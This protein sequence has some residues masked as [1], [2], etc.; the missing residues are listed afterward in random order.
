MG[1]LLTPDSIR[2]RLK[3]YNIA[4]AALFDGSTGYLSYAPS[5]T[6]N[7]R[8]WTT[9]FWVMRHGTG[10]DYYLNSNQYTGSSGIAALYHENDKV[11]QYFHSNTTFPYGYVAINKHIDMSSFYMI[12]WVVDSN[13]N[14]SLTYIDGVLIDDSTITPASGFDFGINKAGALMTFGKAAWGTSAYGNY[15]IANLHHIDGQALVPTD[16]AELD[17]RT[18]NWK[19]KKYTGTYG[20]NGFYLDFSDAGALGTDVSG[21]GNNWIVNGTV[22]QVRSTPTNTYA[23]WN[24]LVYNPSNTYSNGNLTVSEGTATTWRSTESTLL[25]PAKSNMLVYAECY[26]P[27]TS[28]TQQG[29]FGVNDH[30]HDHYIYGNWVGFWAYDVANGRMIEDGVDTTGYTSSY[31]A[32]NYG[33]ALD[34]ANKKAWFRLN[35]GSWEGGGDPVAGTLPSVTWTHENDLTLCVQM[36]QSNWTL[37]ANEADWTYTPP[38]GF[39]SLCTDYLPAVND[40]I[41]HHFKTVLYVGTPTPQNVNT[42]LAQVDFAWIK[43]RSGPGVDGVW[44]TGYPTIWDNCRPGAHLYTSDIY[45]EYESYAA[46]LSG[47]DI[48]INTYG[49]TW[50]NYDSDQYVAWCASLPKTKTSGWTGSPTIIPLKEIYNDSAMFKMSIVKYIGNGVAG[51]TI[52]HSL[53]VKPGFVIVKGVS[54]A[55]DWLCY[56]SALGATQRIYLNRTYA[57]S[58]ATTAW[59]DTEPTD[60][61]ISLG[62]SGDCNTSGYTYVAYIFAPCDGIKIGSY[63]GNGSTDGPFVNE[64]ISPAWSMFKN[65]GG[66]SWV[67]WDDVRDT[68][69]PITNRLFAED[70]AAEVTTSIVENDYTAN[71]VKVRHS[72]T[73]MNP[74]GGT[75]VYVMI[76]QPNGPTENTAR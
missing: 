7:P 69:N 52:P 75:I 39:K 27:T 13:S 58:T 15:T 50:I 56:H 25:I 61:V 72:N 62:T 71:G 48:Q 34:V 18:G 41:D 73:S 4:H 45:A 43:A 51:A 49:N 65:V 36:Y 67:I 53:G 35:G 29:L 42:G 23:T 37:K 63:T 46:Q 59:N 14:T 19:A 10:V 33:M 44:Y 3:A 57:V 68:S 6:G 5:I 60:T 16:F 40:S 8:K 64:G 76:G 20:T 54:N 70:S 26:S 31:G 74:S 24:P 32:I 47:A 2:A 17:L 22:T 12:T 1:M 38:T 55:G 11:Y 66:S 28:G 21:N 9:N 30:T